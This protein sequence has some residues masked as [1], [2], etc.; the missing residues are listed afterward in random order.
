MLEGSTPKNFGRGG[1]L[2]IQ[3]ENKAFSSNKE[4]F[5]ESPNLLLF[6]DYE[7]SQ[8]I[9]ISDIDN[10]KIEELKQVFIKKDPH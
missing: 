4:I 9:R 10:L 2:N 6:L 1:S 8:G 5:T 3:Q 7:K